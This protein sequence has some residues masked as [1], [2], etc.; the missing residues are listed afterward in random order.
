MSNDQ[1]H[2]PTRRKPEGRSGLAVWCTGLLAESPIFIYHQSH[3]FLLSKP[4]STTNDNL[5]LTPYNVFYYGI[6]SHT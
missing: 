4:K 1:S 2:Q 5:E 6:V 3:H